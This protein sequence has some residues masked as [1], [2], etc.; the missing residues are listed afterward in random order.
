[1]IVKERG[2]RGDQGEGEGERRNEKKRFK[3]VMLA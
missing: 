2:E 1:M 3:I